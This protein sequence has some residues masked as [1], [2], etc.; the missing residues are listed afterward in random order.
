MN[1]P[2]KLTTLRVLLVPVFMFFM[3]SVTLFD[4]EFFKVYGI[5]FALII[6]VV[7]S[8]TDYFDGAIA[9]KHNLVTDFGKFMDPLAD[10]VLTTTA[11]IYLVQYAFV[12]NVVIIIVLTREFAGSGIRMIAASSANAKVIPASFAGKLK[13]VMQMVAIILALVTISLACMGVSVVISNYHMILL[14]INIMMWVMAVATIISGMQYI[15]PNIDL[16][17]NAK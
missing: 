16:V 2:N 14:A 15:M 9:R 6:F 7:A 12:S 10:K 1:L 3:E 17:K 11:L 13:T 8:I 5:L 4:N